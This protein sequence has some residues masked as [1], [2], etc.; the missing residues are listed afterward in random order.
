[1]EGRGTLSKNPGKSEEQRLAHH[2]AREE[3]HLVCH[4]KHQEALVQ[5]CVQGINPKTSVGAK[6][7]SQAF[8]LAKAAANDYITPILQA[9][10]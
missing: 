3:Q 10:Y 7:G 6:C 9:S 1:M 2:Q 8:N 4:H 5:P